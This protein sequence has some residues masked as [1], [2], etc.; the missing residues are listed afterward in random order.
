MGS[1]PKC[2]D[3]PKGGQNHYLV[4]I[5]YACFYDFQPAQ[6]PFK[7]LPKRY[8]KGFPKWYIPGYHKSI[9]GAF[10]VAPSFCEVWGP[11]S[12]LNEIQNKLQNRFQ[13]WRPKWS[14]K[15]GPTWIQN[16]I[17]KLGSQFPRIHVSLCF[18]F[19]FDICLDTFCISF[20]MFF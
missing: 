11:T 18:F 19:F 2:D 13:I 15:W 16:E 8:P 7:M 1:E 14:P 4:L 20:W 5:N 6:T 9:F 3:Y 12:A 17:Q 10:L